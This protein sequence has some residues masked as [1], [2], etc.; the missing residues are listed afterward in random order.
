[1]SYGKVKLI[2]FFRRVEHARKPAT[3]EKF[4][5][6]SS[7]NPT[8]TQTIWVGNWHVGKCTPIAWYYLQRRQNKIPVQIVMLMLA[9]G[10]HPKSCFA[11]IYLLPQLSARVNWQDTGKPT[12]GGFGADYAE[13]M[14]IPFR[15]GWGVLSIQECMIIASLTP[16]A[17]AISGIPDAVKQYRFKN[18]TI[19]FCCLCPVMFRLPQE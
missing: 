13:V 4:D 8:W 16:L 10:S 3:I 1:M 9:L 19:S 6:P 14:A 7:W 12:V 15:W 5:R 17:P 11:I 18:F 2:A